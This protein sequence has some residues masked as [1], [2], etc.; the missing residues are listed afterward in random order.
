[1]SHIKRAPWKSPQQFQSRAEHEAAH[2]KARQ[3]IDDG[4]P[5]PK[6][7]VPPLAKTPDMIAATAA[8]LA[9]AHTAWTEIELAIGDARTPWREQD[10]DIGSCRWIAGRKLLVV[11]THGGAFM[12]WRG[13]LLAGSDQ[14]TVT[15]HRLVMAKSGRPVVFDTRYDGERKLGGV[16]DAGGTL[17]RGWR[18]DPPP[19][20]LD[21]R[22]VPDVAAMKSPGHLITTP[23]TWRGRH[24]W[25]ILTFSDEVVV[26]RDR[27]PVLD[28]SGLP[29]CFPSTQAAKAF[30]ERE[31]N[32]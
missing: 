29:V 1:M 10:R 21:S 8:V 17:P 32:Q 12:G 16:A 9:G 2:E 6:D 7:L 5:W 20:G 4:F 11:S 24:H 19:D 23:I 22:W 3:L 14:G 26:Y 18:W 31:D 13:R 25:L 28:S 30:C 27:N 15:E